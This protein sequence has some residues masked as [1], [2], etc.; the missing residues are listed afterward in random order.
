MVKAHHI[1]PL[2]AL[3]G[4]VLAGPASAQQPAAAKQLYVVTYIDVFPN[5]AADTNRLLQ[6][7]ASESR[8]DPGSVRFEVLRD[9]ERTNHFTIV[10]VWQNRQTYDAHL[11]LDHTKQFREKIH[12]GLGSPFD[13][14]YYNSMP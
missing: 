10:E 12:P 8:K 4:L 1:L 3:A 11:A 5:F 2:L 13:E 9:V 14:R 7:F 6:Q